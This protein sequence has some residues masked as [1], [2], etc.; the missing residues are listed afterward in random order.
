VAT[1]VPAIRAQMGDLEYF[2]S[3]VT[4]GEAARMVDFVEQV[5][6]WTSETPPELK[7]QRKLNVQRVEREM[8]P[9]LLYSDDHFYSALTVEIRSAPYADAPRGVAF[10]SRQTFPGGVEFGVLTLDG[11]ETLYALD[12]QHRLKSIEI[13]IRQK[14]Q[15]AREHIAL[16]LVPFNSVTRSQTLFSDLNRYAKGPSKSIALLF[17]HRELLARI[18]KSVAQVVPLLRERVNMESTSLSTNARH[19][20]TLSTLYE[21]TR[22]LVDEERVDSAEAEEAAVADLADVFGVLTE[23]IPEWRLVAEGEEHPAYLRQRFLH[24]HGVAQQAIALTVARLRAEM[25]GD[26]REVVAGLGEVDWRLANKEWQGVALHGGRVHNT[27]TSIRLLCD[28]LHNKLR[29]TAAPAL[30]NR[31]SVRLER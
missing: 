28:V 20:I 17:T 26:W 3:V 19:F 25:R 2:V 15:I 27:A 31:G 1:F 10:E 23:A 9:Y 12:G 14:P 11:T 4:L 24:M 5:D 18:A 8:V 30:A 7:L 6:D 29:G 22:A 16:I 21:M 13:A